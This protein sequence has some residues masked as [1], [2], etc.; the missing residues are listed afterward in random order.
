MAMKRD[1]V[2]EGQVGYGVEGDYEHEHRFAEHEHEAATEPE[3]T[4]GPQRPIGSRKMV[5]E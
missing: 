3:P 4:D 2:A 5:A 1:G